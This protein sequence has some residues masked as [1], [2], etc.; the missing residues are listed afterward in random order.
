MNY[1]KRKTRQ[2]R[3]A[4]NDYFKKKAED[5]FVYR[6]PRVDR[7]LTPPRPCRYTGN[8][9][10]YRIRKSIRDR[11]RN[12]R[13]LRI[14]ESVEVPLIQ[15]QR[16]N[17]GEPLQVFDFEEEHY[18]DIVRFWVHWLRG[19]HDT[20]R[21]RELAAPIR[22]LIRLLDD[23]RTGARTEL[24]DR[25]FEARKQR[26]GRRHDSEAIAQHKLAV[27]L[28][29]KTLTEAALSGQQRA[30]RTISRCMLD[31]SLKPD[32][33]GSIPD[34]SRKVPVEPDSNGSEFPVCKLIC[35]SFG[36]QQFFFQL[37]RQIQLTRSYRLDGFRSLADS[38]YVEIEQKDGVNYIKDWR[39]FVKE[40]QKSLWDD[41]R[42]S[43]YEFIKAWLKAEELSCKVI[44]SLY[45]NWGEL[46]R[47]PGYTADTRRHPL[48]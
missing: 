6:W 1:T 14:A 30:I 2:R 41:L 8:C 9:R 40:V 35:C 27:G 37:Y 13:P 36:F 16:Q 28:C 5:A 45:S 25:L 4:R 42:A 12:N 17:N 32:I 29:Y 44:L 38:I 21:G 23:L 48:P 20:V 24:T 7:L 11:V 18:Q 10:Y 31:L 47:F 43:R 46:K 22:D 15:Y 26:K 19:V 3:K 34:L 39:Q 33:I